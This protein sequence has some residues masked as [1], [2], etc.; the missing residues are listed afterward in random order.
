ARAPAVRR[1][2]VPTS[3]LHPATRRLALAGRG[4]AAAE[5]GSAVCLVTHDAVM[6]ERWAG[7]VLD[8][9][10]HAP[11]VGEIAA[12]ERAPAGTEPDARAV[13]V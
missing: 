2:A 8:L 11:R 10:A 7:R 5:A 4:V 12:A 3:R 13:E 6:A 9:A 1:P